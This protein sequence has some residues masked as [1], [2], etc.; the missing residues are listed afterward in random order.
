M[1]LISQKCVDFIITCLIVLNEFK[2]LPLKLISN[3]FVTFFKINICFFFQVF[4][5]SQMN[6]SSDN[7]MLADTLS[8]KTFLKWK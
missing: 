4:K 6:Y 5:I 7:R 1:S 8:A 2:V 3:F